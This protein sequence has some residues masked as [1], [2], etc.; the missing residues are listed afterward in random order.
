ME[1]ALF[2]LVISS[3]TFHYLDH[4]EKVPLPLSTPAGYLDRPRAPAPDYIIST[5]ATPKMPNQL[6]YSLHDAQ[7]RVNLDCF[8]PLLD[9]PHVGSIPYVPYSHQEM[10]QR[11]LML[12]PGLEY[13][14]SSI[15]PD[16][17]AV[18]HNLQNATHTAPYHTLPQPKSVFEVSLR[19]L[20]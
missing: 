20:T 19:L 6:Q 12:I 4:Q 18:P 3:V 14:S 15:T 16:R 11:I 5:L 8:T 9:G 17:R 1:W 13:S 7:D 2:V 10:P